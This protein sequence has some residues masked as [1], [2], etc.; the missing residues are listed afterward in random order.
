MSSDPVTVL[1]GSVRSTVLVNEVFPLVS[2][3]ST[4][5]LNSLGTPS[6][7]GDSCGQGCQCWP[8]MRQIWN[9]LRSVFSTVWL[10]EP[11]CTETDL[12]KSQIC[13][14]WGQSDPICVPNF[15][16]QVMGM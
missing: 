12:K 16:S 2:S 14:I 8:Q 10:A 1:G 13:P 9:I 4:G 5:M 3:I 15:T 7:W 6:A 11:N